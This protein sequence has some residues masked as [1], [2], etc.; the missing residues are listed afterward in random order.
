MK[1]HTHFPIFHRHPQ[2]YTETKLVDVE[3][4]EEREGRE[5]GKREEGREEDIRI[6]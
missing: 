1:D 5:E 3:G 2:L 6:F 4:P